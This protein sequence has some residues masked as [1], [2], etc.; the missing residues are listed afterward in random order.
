MLKKP[1]FVILVLALLCGSAA[2]QQRQAPGG[3]PGGVAAAA[4]SARDQSFDLRGNPGGLGGMAHGIAGVLEKEQT[5]LGTMHQRAGYVRFAVFPQAN[6]YLGPVVILTDGGSASTS[7]IFA[8]GLQELARAVVVGERTAGAALPSFFQRL[9]T[10]AL[11]ST[12]SVISKLQMA[13]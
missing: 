13:R 6:P 7:E 12:R 2:P 8:A 9:P 5:S 3:V 11:F 4:S 10:G 1:L